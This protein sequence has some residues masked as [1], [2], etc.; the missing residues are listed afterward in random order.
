MQIIVSTLFLL[1]IHHG[2]SIYVG[3]WETG[4]P[5]RRSTRALD[6]FKSMVRCTTPHRHVLEAYNGYGC[7]CGF[8]GGGNPVDE[9]DRCCMNHDQCYSEAIKKHVC[10]NTDVYIARYEFATTECRS[11]AASITCKG[12][13]NHPSHRK[14]ALEICECDSQ[15]AL[16]F[17]TSSYDSKFLDHDRSACKAE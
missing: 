10:S 1:L 7:W 9:T 3:D 2:T 15:A 16:C 4:S 13:T 12:S 11:D 6:Q 14:C 17:K 8:G 5:R